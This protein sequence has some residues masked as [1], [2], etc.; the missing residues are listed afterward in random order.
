MDVVSN[1]SSCRALSEIVA[2]LM[3]SLRSPLPN[4]EE[5][6]SREEGRSKRPKLRR[7][8]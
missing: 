3:A 5:G 1:E 8:P 6:P 2:A 7:A 4:V